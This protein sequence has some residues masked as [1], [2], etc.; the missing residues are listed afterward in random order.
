MGQTFPCPKC[1]SQN[2][3][4]HRFCP[5][6]GATLNIQREPKTNWCKR[7]PNWT[8]AIASVPLLCLALVVT[9]PWP[10]GE[11]YLW[12]VFIFTAEWLLTLPIAIRV[13]KQ[14]GRS[15][16]YPLWCLL[17]IAGGLFPP[18]WYL[19]AMGG[20]LA[21]II[22][23]VLRN[24]LETRERIIKKKKLAAARSSTKIALV[25]LL[26]IVLLAVG[27]LAYYHL[28]LDVP[29]YTADQVIEVAKSYSPEC[30]MLG[31]VPKFRA[32]ENTDPSSPSWAV[33]YLGSGKWLV[34][35]ECPSAT[36]YWHF[37]EDTGKLE[38]TYKP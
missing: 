20:L 11:H 10:G 13:L 25:V 33:E 28:S 7:H 2:P 26:C 29:R 31:R 30:P 35:K 8:L 23:L 3:V 27:S 4:G 16:L 24:R 18:L 9:L 6:C 14:K 19:P 1:G 37:Y 17:P 21:L 22:P 36:G 12:W 32:W 5:T 38:G 15:P 34:T